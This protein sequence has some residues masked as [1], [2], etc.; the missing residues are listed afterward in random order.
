MRISGVDGVDDLVDGLTKN[1]NFFGPVKTGLS[2][3]LGI[4]SQNKSS[5]L[6]DWLGGTTNAK[7]QTN[8]RRAGSLS[9]TCRGR[10][11]ASGDSKQAATAAPPKHR[12]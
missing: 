8:R 4:Y 5:T 11:E 6:L 9:E 3:S 7:A 12:E 1:L 2:H 10:R